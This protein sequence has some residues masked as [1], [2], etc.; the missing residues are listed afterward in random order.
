MDVLTLIIIATL[1]GGALALILY[2]LWRQT[3]PDAIFRIDRS[4]QT[5]EEYEA[6]YQALLDAIRDLMFDH[7]MG[8][9]STE[10]Y[11]TLLNRTK[12]EAAG[13]RRHI[14][15]LNR[16]T[17]E[18][19]DAALDAKIETLIAQMNP[20]GLNGDEPLLHEVEAEIELL[21]QVKPE[22]PADHA[23]RFSQ[24]GRTCPQCDKPFQP[25]DAFCSRCGHSLAGLEVKENICPECGYEYQP[26][27]AFCTRCG[28]A[29][30]QTP[31]N[32]KT[33]EFST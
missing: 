25:G 17:T 33:T 9:V 31:E 20:A 24:D 12:L 28:T 23:P 2:P 30:T 15:R 3:R 6:R 26:D 10:D 7:E 22:Q 8:K 13:V 19:I 16:S 32:A 21:K 5:L 27:D 18:A 29:L 4:G 11:E 1:I 14:D